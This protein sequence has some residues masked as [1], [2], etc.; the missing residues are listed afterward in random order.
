M[1][2]FLL[3]SGVVSFVLCAGAGGYLIASSTPQ[4][5]VLCIG[6]GLYFIGK[7]F[8]VGPVLISRALKY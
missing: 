1:K 2:I 4:Y 6:M 7:A 8:F 3:I 5:D